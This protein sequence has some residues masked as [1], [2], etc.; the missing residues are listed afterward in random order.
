MFVFG[1]V[2]VLV[3]VLPSVFAGVSTQNC[4]ILV[5][6]HEIQVGHTLLSLVISD[7]AFKDFRTKPDNLRPANCL[8]GVE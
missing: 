6:T 3:L 1:P 5:G 4:H 8:S 2:I 7:A